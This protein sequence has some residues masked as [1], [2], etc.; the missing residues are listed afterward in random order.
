[1]WFCNILNVFCFQVLKQVSESEHC[2][3]LKNGSI[4][5][6]SN[7]FFSCPEQLNRWP[8]QSLTDWLTHSITF[9]FDIT[10][11]PQRLVTFE[12]FD[13][14]DEETSPDN[15]WWKFL[16]T[17]FGDNFWLQ[18]FDDNFWWQFLMT[19]F[20]WQ[21][22]VTIFDDNFWKQFLMTLFDDNLWWQFSDFLKHLL[23]FWQLR[24]WIHDNLCYLTINCDTGQHSQFL[25]C[26]FSI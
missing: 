7:M 25:R 3:Y 21:F 6:Y 26:F 23:Q 11:R 9:T 24:T 5:T 15:F 18:L 10:E 20:W 16:V 1:M 12:T 14:S 22:L 8:C 2:T 4:V 17:I 19:I 13:Q